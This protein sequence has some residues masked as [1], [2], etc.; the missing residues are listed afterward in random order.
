MKK[1]VLGLI[2]CTAFIAVSRPASADI[3]DFTFT[4]QNGVTVTGWLKTQP[5]YSLPGYYHVFGGQIDVS[6]TSAF[7]AANPNFAIGS[8]TEDGC[9]GGWPFGDWC[10]RDRTAQVTWG[11]LIVSDAPWGWFTPDAPLMFSFDGKSTPEFLLGVDDGSGWVDEFTEVS[12]DHGIDIAAVYEDEGSDQ[13]AITPEP[14]SWILLG[15]GAM[16][17]GFIAWRRF[18]NMAS[19]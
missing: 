8:A 18:P 11:S 14:S 9:G 15:T 1:F 17:L 10:K 16:A 4:G 6:A 5:D 3:L 2:A 12:P 19:H 7:L 13:G